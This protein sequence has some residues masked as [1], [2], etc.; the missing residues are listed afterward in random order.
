MGQ[1][2]Y[3]IIIAPFIG[4]TDDQIEIS[5]SFA[6]MLRRLNEGIFWFE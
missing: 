1:D 2:N 4:D 5:S 6:D 3:Q